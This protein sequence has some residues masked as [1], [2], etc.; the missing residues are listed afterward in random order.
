L[1]FGGDGGDGQGEGKGR[2]GCGEEGRHV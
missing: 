1:T 2:D